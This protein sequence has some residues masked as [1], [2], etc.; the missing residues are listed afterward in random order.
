MSYKDITVYALVTA[1]AERNALRT[2]KDEGRYYEPGTIN[3]LLLTNMKLTFRAMTRAVITATEAKIAALQDLDVRSFQIGRVH[4]ATG[5]GTDNIIVVQGTGK[6][7]DIC[8]E[9]SKMG[10]L[11]A[12]AVY[13]G[14]Q[15]A[16]KKQNA[17]VLQRS[18]FRRLEERKISLF[19]LVSR[20]TCADSR[21]RGDLCARLESLLLIPRYASFISSALSLSDDHERGLLRDLSPYK[22]WCDAISQEIAGQDI[23]VMQNLVN[24]KNGPVVIK[25]A[26]NAL[27]NGLYVRE[28]QIP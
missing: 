8:G 15:G 24:L 1:G 17:L 19:G 10:E 25:M 4:Q 5:T 27:L 14:V 12:G 16:L 11:I 9:H 22:L 6:E 20:G 18:I 21:K 26:F 7:I 28:Q 3:L 23:L 13:A 2:G